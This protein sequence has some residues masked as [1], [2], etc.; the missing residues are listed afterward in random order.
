M[1]LGILVMVVPT[2]RPEG[3]GP[4]THASWSRELAGRYP[5]GTTLKVYRCFHLAPLARF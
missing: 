3:R 1:E 4:Y 5:L 2:N